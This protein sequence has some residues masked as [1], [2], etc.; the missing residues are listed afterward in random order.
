MSMY[1]CMQ[2]ERVYWY[3]ECL[4]GIEMLLNVSLSTLTFRC[5]RYASRGIITII[6]KK[7]GGHETFITKINIRVFFS[8]FG[9]ILNHKSLEL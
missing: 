3:C 4:N 8:N 7:C 5:D 2:L 6:M 9:K 1:V